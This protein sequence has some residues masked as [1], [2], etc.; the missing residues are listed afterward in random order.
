M[1]QRYAAVADRVA[2]SV[3]AGDEERIRFVKGQ[4]VMVGGMSFRLESDVIVLGTSKSMDWLKGSPSSGESVAIDDQL[5]YFK[6][7]SD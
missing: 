3:V 2:R 1:K 7:Y 5:I 4:Q 6:D